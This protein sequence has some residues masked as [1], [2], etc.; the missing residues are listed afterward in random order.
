MIWYSVDIQIQ[1]TEDLDTCPVLLGEPCELWG[2]CYADNDDGGLGKRY[3]ARTRGTCKDPTTGYRPGCAAEVAK[4]AAPPK[5]YGCRRRIGGG[6]LVVCGQHGGDPGRRSRPRVIQVKCKLTDCA[7]V[8]IS[9][10]SGESLRA[11]VVL[12]PRH[13]AWPGSVLRGKYRV[14]DY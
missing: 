1:L 2:G 6:T 13:C 3:E 5:S 12:A 14:D 7:I 11:E 8:S 10:P 4:A 9:K